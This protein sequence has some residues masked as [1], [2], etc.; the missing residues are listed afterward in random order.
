MYIGFAFNVNRFYSLIMLFLAVGL[1]A[2]EED[3]DKLLES[4]EIRKNGSIYHPA[5]ISS[6]ISMK[7]KTPF[8]CCDIMEMDCNLS[9]TCFFASFINS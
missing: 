1:S 4:L 9:F 5:C 6:V 7:L 8:L 3:V 2:E